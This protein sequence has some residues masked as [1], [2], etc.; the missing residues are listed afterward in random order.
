MMQSVIISVFSIIILLVMAGSFVYF[1]LRSIQSEMIEDWHAILDN[2]RYR[3]DKIPN[4]IEIIKN[5]AP[6][7]DQAISEIIKLRADCWPM[8]RADKSR[9]H[10]ELAVSEAI[11][12]LISLSKQFPDMAK[13]TNFLSLKTELKELGGQVESLTEKYNNNVRKYNNIRGSVFLLPFVTLLRFPNVSIFE[14]E[15]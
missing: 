14:Y 8:S 3:L 13:D 1:Y 6:E 11:N 15:P 2:L 5:F 9:V 10:M 4:L 12:N 7:Q